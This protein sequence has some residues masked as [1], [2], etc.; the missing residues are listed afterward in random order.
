MKSLK[1]VQFFPLFLK[2]DDLE[3]YRVSFAGGIF[4]VILKLAAKGKRLGEK[5]CDFFPFS[6]ALSEKYAHLFS[7]IVSVLKLDKIQ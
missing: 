4:P 1:A 6:D 2:L 5:L 3:K 7:Y